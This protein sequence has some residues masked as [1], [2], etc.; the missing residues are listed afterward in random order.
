[1]DTHIHTTTLRY[2]NTHTQLYKHTQTHL[3]T[4]ALNLD[5]VLSHHCIAFEEEV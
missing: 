1:M 3:D 2:T 4:I 5:P